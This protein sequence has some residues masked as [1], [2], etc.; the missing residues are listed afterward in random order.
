MSIMP[1]VPL[2]AGDPSVL[3]PCRSSPE[4]TTGAGMTHRHSKFTRALAGLIAMAP[5]G[6]SDDG[7]SGSDPGGS[8]EEPVYALAT[9]VWSD[10]A[11]TGYVALMKN[12]DVEE[13]SL[14]DAREFPG[15]TSIGVVDG[16]L[17]VNPSWEDLTIERYRIT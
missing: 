4:E 7:S 14:D 9:L 3:S 11:P 13:V 16:Q 10:G 12:L 17:L 6:C 8:S 5:T 2:A 15:Y 1:K